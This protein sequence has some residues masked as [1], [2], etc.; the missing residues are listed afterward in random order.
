[1]RRYDKK[2]HIKNANLLFE[3]RC[4]EVERFDATHYQEKLQQQD[5][6]PVYDEEKE[7]K[8]LIRA[9]N[10]RGQKLFEE[11]VG[12]I[13]EKGTDKPKMLSLLAKALIDG[14]GQGL[15]SHLTDLA[16]NAGAAPDEMV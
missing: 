16:P 9:N 2:E 14:I 3:Q 7:I 13:Y 8:N 1:M 5:D 11:Q 15:E 10:W 6:F 12:W 4:N